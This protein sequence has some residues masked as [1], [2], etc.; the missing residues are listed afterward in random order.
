MFSVGVALAPAHT[1]IIDQDDE[2]YLI[3]VIFSPRAQFLAQIFSTQQRVNRDETA[4]IADNE[5]DFRFLIS[6]TFE[7]TPHVEKF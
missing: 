6:E 4:Q 2:P 7:I 1:S 3:F 5:G